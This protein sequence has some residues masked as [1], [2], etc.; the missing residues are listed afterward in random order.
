MHSAYV[1][2]GTLAGGRTVTLDEALPLNTERVRLVV[3]RGEPFPE[4]PSYD[5][6]LSRI[7][8]RQRARGHTP[9]TREQIDAYIQAE[10]DSWG[11]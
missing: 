2:A 11:D 1:V 9:R 3:E 8:A 5:E 6:V 7:R 4:R 10:R